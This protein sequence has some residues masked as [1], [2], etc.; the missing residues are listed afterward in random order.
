MSGI[1]SL[2]VFFCLEYRMQSVWGAFL[3]LAS[4]NVLEGT[5]ASAFGHL[6]EVSGLR[7]DTTRAQSPLPSSPQVMCMVHLYVRD[8]LVETK[9]Q[10][11]T[12][13]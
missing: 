12:T 6:L 10:S 1:N 5:H 2:G 7:H 3:A 9:N 4:W 13:I 8:L 11:C